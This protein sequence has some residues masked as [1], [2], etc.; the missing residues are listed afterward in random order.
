MKEKT[1]EQLAKEAFKHGYKHGK[2]EKNGG[3]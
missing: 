3:E 2:N 1:I